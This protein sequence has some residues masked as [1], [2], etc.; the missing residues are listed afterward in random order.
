[1]Y[2]PISANVLPHYMTARRIASVGLTIVL[3]G[4]IAI[5]TVCCGDPEP[6]TITSLYQAPER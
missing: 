4:S 5:A 2:D 3:L 6:T 1:M